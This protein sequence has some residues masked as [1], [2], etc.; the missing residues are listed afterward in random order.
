MT[1][2][3]ASRWSCLCPRYKVACY[4]SC[5]FPRLLVWPHR[6]LSNLEF[7]QRLHVK[8]PHGSL[9]SVTVFSEILRYSEMAS[10]RL[11]VIRAMLP[12]RGRKELVETRRFLYK[13]RGAVNTGTVLVARELVARDL[14]QG[15]ADFS[16]VWH[17][18]YWRR[19]INPNVGAAS[20][21]RRL[22]P[23]KALAITREGYSS[24]PLRAIAI[25]CAVAVDKAGTG[26]EAAYLKTSMYSMMIL[27]DK[28]Y[29]RDVHV[30]LSPAPPLPWLRIEETDYETAICTS[31]LREGTGE[32]ETRRSGVIHKREC[33][34]DG[35]WRCDVCGCAEGRRVGRPPRTAVPIPSSRTPGPDIQW[36]GGL[37]PAAPC[38][39]S[40]FGRVEPRVGMTR[41]QMQ[42]GLLSPVQRRL[43]DPVTLR[44]HQDRIR[45][46][47]GV[48]TRGLDTLL[49]GQHNHSNI[50]PRLISLDEDNSHSEELVMARDVIC[51]ILP[52]PSILTFE[53]AVRKFFVP[54]LATR[55]MG[56]FFWE[57]QELRQLCEQVAFSEREAM[58]ALDEAR[59]ALR[60]IV[61]E[62][63]PTP[64]PRPQPLALRRHDPAPYRTRHHI[65]H[66]H[67]CHDA[68]TCR[69]SRQRETARAE[70]RRLQPPAAPP[71]PQYNLP[72][73]YPR[74]PRYPYSV[75]PFRTP[76]M[77]SPVI[78]PHPPSHTS[79]TPK[80]V[81]W[82]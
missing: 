49:H 79:H 76:P 4:G 65:H 43:D 11:S 81:H 25:V 42:E 19:R 51:G 82:A 71:V 1:T 54:L 34:R 18:T 57:R 41:T 73:F 74:Q 29:S 66:L 23:R 59:R 12:A 3:C 60:R 80:F 44:R 70:H 33:A 21:F 46:F 56:R 62:P 53:T 5:L 55:A 40:G 48:Q 52:G 10:F 77:P 26:R 36:E 63:E 6:L 31:V 27:N 61:Q 72:V 68:T 50:L 78:P 37:R 39:P 7:W 17:Y 24:P 16:L 58:D 47:L 14:A 75:T 28:S 67:W 30:E 20:A 15:R 2:H 8:R 9:H 69:F 45:A 22:K 38:P 35:R 64:S 32:E 13:L